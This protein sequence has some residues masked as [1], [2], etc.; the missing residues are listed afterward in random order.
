VND[1]TKFAKARQA[2]GPGA[3]RLN[4]LAVSHVQ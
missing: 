4:L 1:D 2:I 3:Q